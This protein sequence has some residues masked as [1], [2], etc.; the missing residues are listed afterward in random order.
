VKSQLSQRLYP[1]L[2]RILNFK[3]AFILFSIIAIVIIAL[4]ADTVG[5]KWLQAIGFFTMGVF[6]TLLLVCTSR[7]VLY[8]SFNPSRHGTLE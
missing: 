6:F 3:H 7:Y 2:I 8:K 1:H 5:R 4:L